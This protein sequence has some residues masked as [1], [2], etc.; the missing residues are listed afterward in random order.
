MRRG[1][2]EEQFG[3]RQRN[4]YGGSYGTS[5][6][7]R[8]RPYSTMGR[9]SRM[10]APGMSTIRSMSTMR[11]Q[12]L[13]NSTDTLKDVIAEAAT[14]MQYEYYGN[15]H[16]KHHGFPLPTSPGTVFEFICKHCNRVYRD[17]SDA[18][19]NKCEGCGSSEVAVKD[20]TSGGQHN[21][22]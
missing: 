14:L 12:R 17:L 7:G 19:M 10:R 18:M 9:K 15:W 16:G 5:P 3:M 22:R 8:R 6:F 4:M 13:F 21:E 20:E 11:T 1:N 2:M